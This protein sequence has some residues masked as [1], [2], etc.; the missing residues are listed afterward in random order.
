M[1]AVVVCHELTLIR[2]AGWVP[3]VAPPHQHRRKAEDLAEGCQLGEFPIGL[4]FSALETGNSCCCR[5][6]GGCHQGE[7]ER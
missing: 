1:S 3:Q 4:I 7:F 6:D 5:P 2:M